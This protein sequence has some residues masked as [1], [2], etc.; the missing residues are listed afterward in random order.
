M[1]TSHEKEVLSGKKVIV[2]GGSSGMYFTDFSVGACS[3]LSDGSLGMGLSV[4]AAALARDAA[5]VISSS[6]QDYMKKAI[7]RLKQRAEGRPNVSVEGHVFDTKN[8]GAL[9]KFLS[10]EGPFDHLVRSW[11]CYPADILSLMTP[12]VNLQVIIAGGLLKTL[13]LPIN[14]ITE[15]LKHQFEYVWLFA[16]PQ[17]V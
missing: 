4:A 15:D 2:V 12:R 10:K 11:F 1:N 16:A 5:V 3:S 17:E 14:E 13:E 8:F 7:E 6:S 9:K